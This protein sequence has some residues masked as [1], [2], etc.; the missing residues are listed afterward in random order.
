M[1]KKKKKR[2]EEGKLV[3]D[4]VLVLRKEKQQFMQCSIRNVSTD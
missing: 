2:S 3:S 4:A 1:W